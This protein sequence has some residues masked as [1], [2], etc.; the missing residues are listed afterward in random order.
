MKLKH[1]FILVAICFVWNMAS[2][3]QV[4]YTRT[5]KKYHSK[6]CRYLSNSDYVCTLE[7]AKKRGLSAC[8]QCNPPKQT[9]ETQ[10][11]KQ[12]RKKPTSTSTQ[13]MAPLPK[14]QNIE[15]S[16]SPFIQ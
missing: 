12:Q 9:E 8:S 10:Q 7:Q 15:H 2:A 14:R 3:Q 1:W 16:Y 11:K 4:H 5:G 13:L 6:G